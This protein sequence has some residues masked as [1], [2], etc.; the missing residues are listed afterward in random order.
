M[1]GLRLSL[2]MLMPPSLKGSCPTWRLGQWRRVLPFQT[3]AR[4]GNTTM[5]SFNLYARASGIGFSNPANVYCFPGY[6]N[7]RASFERSEFCGARLAD[8]AKPH[9]EHAICRIASRFLP[10]HVFERSPAKGGK[11]RND[12]ADQ[13]CRESSPIRRLFHLLGISRTTE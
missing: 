7:G 2:R 4:L 1:C 3:R 8:L 13:T 6:S 5:P 9:P 11:L 10:V 12:T